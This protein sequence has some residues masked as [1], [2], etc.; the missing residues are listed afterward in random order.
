MNVIDRF[1]GKTFP[2]TE[3]GC[4]IWEGYTDSKMGYGMFWLNG[5]MRLSHRVAYELFVGEI[6]NGMQVCHRCDIPSC[7]NPN[8][9]WLGTNV[10]N[11]HDK[12]NKGRSARLQGSRHPGA[13]LDEDKVRFIRSCKTSARRLAPM[14][15]IDRSTINYIRQ[16]KLW[17]HL[18]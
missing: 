18:S 10:D 15:G 6:P 2:V 1:M 7:V 11:V 4:W 9:L 12:V 17:S 8:H 3:S 5:T 16:G 13:K 14:L